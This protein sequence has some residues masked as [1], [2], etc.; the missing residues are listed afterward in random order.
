MVDHV[1]LLLA[2]ESAAELSWH[3][4]LLKGRSSYEVSKAYPEVKLDA[5]TN[6]LWQVSFNSRVVPDDQLATV[7]NYIRTQDQRLEN[8]SVNSLKANAAGFNL[9]Y[10]G[11]SLR[12]HRPLPATG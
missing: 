10:G 2:A 12:L 6:A 3:L 5:H 11:L 9:R 7:R 8:M 4:K 1:H